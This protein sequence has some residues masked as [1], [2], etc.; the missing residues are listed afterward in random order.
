MIALCCC[1]LSFRVIKTA[2]RREFHD[3]VNANAGSVSQG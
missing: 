1:M 2:T 3:N